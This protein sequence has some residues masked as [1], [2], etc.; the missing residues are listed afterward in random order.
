MTAWRLPSRSIDLSAGTPLMGILNVTPDSFSDGG[1]YL[2]A[3]AAV[4]RAHRLV[5]DGAAIVDVGGESTR[6]GAEPVPEDEETR[7]VI[8]VVER[9]AG[10]GITV[11]IDTMKPGVAAAAID[12]GAE[13]VNDVTGLADPDMVRL[14]A[15]RGVGVVVMHMQGEPRTMQADPRYGDVVAEVADYLEARASALE[16]AGIAADAIVVDPGIG[17][18]KTIDHNLALLANAGRVGRGRPVLIGHSRKKFLGTLTGIDEAADRDAATA[19]MSVLAVD[20]GAAIL[21]V[22]DVAATDRALRLRAA[23]VAAGDDG[24]SER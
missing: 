24:E 19:V 15:D 23:I 14:C 17:F 16:A 20:A 2:D 11:S 21:R 1:R 8:P 7:R 6:P 13:V 18:G 9:L 5:A 3:D 12:A 10:T 4:A 22:H